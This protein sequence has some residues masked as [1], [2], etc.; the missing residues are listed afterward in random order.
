MSSS[1]V[2]TPGQT[3]GIEREDAPTIRNDELAGGVCLH[4]WIG[5]QLLKIDDVCLCV[6]YLALHSEHFG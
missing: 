6:F 3:V 1:D 4:L 2:Y 5:C